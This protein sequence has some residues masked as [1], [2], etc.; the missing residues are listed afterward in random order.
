LWGK[1]AADRDQKGGDYELTTAHHGSSTGDQVRAADLRAKIE[2]E[3][4]EKLARRLKQKQ[5]EIILMRAFV[6]TATFLL[7]SSAL[8]PASAI[9]PAT[10]E[11]KSYQQKGTDDADNRGG[12]KM[13]PGDD[14][15]V[16]QTGAAAQDK[17]D[18]DDRKV[19]SSKMRPE[20][21]RDRK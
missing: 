2:L 4:N 7:A 6:L 20:G 14:Q 17:V 18:S 13:K 15:T 21:D 9:D 11:T 19:D 12:S 10:P 16:G 8:Y 5:L 1:S 3:R